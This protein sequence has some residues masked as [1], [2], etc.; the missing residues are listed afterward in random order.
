M[1]PARSIV[2]LAAAAAVAA[3]VAGGCSSEPAKPKAETYTSQAEGFALTF[4]SDWKKSTGYGMNLEV[5]PPGQ[6]NPNAFRD[7]IFVRVEG[8]AEALPLED[9]FAIK[10]AKGAKNMPDYKEI[11]K[12]SVKLGGLDARKLVWSYTNGET[13]VTCTA[14][15]LVKGTKGFMVAG[16]ASADRFAQREAEFEQVMSTFRLLGDEAVPAPA[17]K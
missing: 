7:D 14:Y 5:M 11:E 16:Q 17:G 2:L 8:L 1:T 4:Q 3:L 9:Y 13:P 15:F 6:D 10:V 12:S